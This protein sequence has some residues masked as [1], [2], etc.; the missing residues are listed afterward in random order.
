MIER[1]QDYLKPFAEWLDSFGFLTGT[2]IILAI[3][4]MFR[5]LFRSVKKSVPAVEAALKFYKA[6]F[7][8]PQFMEETTKSLQEVRHEVLPNEGGS[9]RDDLE[10]VTLI[11]EQ[12][13]ALVKSTILPRLDQVES[14]DRADHERLQALEDAA[15]L[16]DTITRRREQRATKH[17]GNTGGVDIGLPYPQYPTEE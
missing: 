15:N 3:L 11:S 7:Q 6:L 14:H 13:N 12:T 8:L 16:D 17:G 1:M 10:T 5:T 4:L 9:M 2:L